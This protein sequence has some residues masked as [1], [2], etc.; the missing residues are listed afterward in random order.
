MQVILG[1]R[2]RLGNIA[3]RREWRAERATAVRVEAKL[4]DK[5]HAREEAARGGRRGQAATAQAEQAARGA[6]W[7][8]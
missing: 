5:L 2:D 1:I 6:A 3:R 4:V 8:G 7:L